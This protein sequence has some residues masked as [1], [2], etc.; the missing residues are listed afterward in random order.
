MAVFRSS[1]QGVRPRVGQPW[2]PALALLLICCATASRGAGV[3]ALP[4]S[5]DESFHPEFLR[6]GTVTR[7]AVVEGGG[8]YVAGSFTQLQ[9]TPATNFA[10]LDAQGKVDRSFAPTVDWATTR[11][12]ALGAPGASIMV[13][14]LVVP[15][16]DGGVLVSG[17]QLESSG[18]GP[19]GLMR[20][21]GQGKRDPHF[22]AR[23]EALVGLLDVAL[24]GAVV[25]PDGRIVVMGK[26]TLVNGVPRQNIARLMPDGSV[27]PSF[28]LP[29][30][31]FPA[32]DLWLTCLALQADGRILVGGTTFPSTSQRGVAVLFRLNP[33]GSMDP[34]FDRS[35]LTKITSSMPA[36]VSAVR[37]QRD[38]KIVLG[39][40]FGQYGS[41]VR[42]NPDGTRDPSFG[43]QDS[44]VT[45]LD[46]L[47]PSGDPKGRW[48]GVGNW[49]GGGWGVLRYNADGTVD[50]TFGLRTLDGAVLDAAVLPG[51]RLV[52]AGSFG[53]GQARRDVDLVDTTGAEQP[54]I[55]SVLPGSVWSALPDPAGRTYV[56]G[57]FEWVNGTP[58]TAIARLNPDG[59]LDE[60]FTD[61]FP[62]AYRTPYSTPY[63]V[64]IA[65][66]S[67]QR[68]LLYAA[69]GY[70]NVLARLSSDGSID[71]TW[72]VQ[73]ASAVGPRFG[74][75]LPDGG[76]ML[77]G[78]TF[79]TLGVWDAFLV[80]LTP[81]G[82]LD[83]SFP[84]VSN[85]PTP[86]LAGFG[87]DSAGRVVIGS[88]TTGVRRIKADGSWDD[89]FTA[90]FDS[91]DNIL[92][93]QVEPDGVVF[94]AH[95]GGYPGMPRPQ[96]A[97][98]FPDGAIDGT[99]SADL[100]HRG[101]YAY[102]TD[103]TRLPDGRFLV[104]L[105]EVVEG[106]YLSA[107]IRLEADGTWDPGFQET[108]ANSGIEQVIALPDGRALV[109]GGFTTLGGNPRPFLAV[110][111]GGDLPGVPPAIETEPE[112][113]TVFE[114][115][116]LA[117]TVLVTG[118]GPLRYEW[119]RD[120]IPVPDAVRR[121]LELP[122]T[123]SW[124][125]G[126]YAVIVSNP[127]GSVTSVM[128]HVQ[129]I[130]TEPL[131]PALNNTSL[132]W[133]CRSP[134][135]DR[136][137]WVG[138]FDITHDGGA[139]A[140]SVPIGDNASAIL[141]APVSTS[142]WIQFWWRVSSETNFDYLQFWIDDR[143]YAA[144]SGESGWQHFVAEVHAGQRVMWMYVKDGS[145]SEGAD[146]GW[147]DE[148]SLQPVVPGTQY[149]IQSGGL[150]PAGAFRL[151]WN[152][153]PQ[154]PFQVE[155]SL[156]LI[157]WTPRSIGICDLFLMEFTDLEP[158]SKPAYFYRVVSP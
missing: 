61:A 150:T 122:E 23:F 19:L 90:P 128:A 55:R 44:T 148:V 74:T 11:Q 153:T 46:Y 141:S 3:D 25:Q 112:D 10:R 65:T 67:Q 73:L 114:G 66:D 92:T 53:A 157:H 33:D 56:S 86:W 119:L 1:T 49:G 132:A 93:L 17:W 149:S 41:L 6:A 29:T 89:T 123:H 100:R 82:D 38:Q 143:P 152:C 40:L 96:L 43:G 58:R 64:P 8:V 76:V 75:F 60:T 136:R 117:L 103:F 99:F 79:P 78:F 142:G 113:T 116:P 110:L 146:C 69:S 126:A 154:A 137:G 26:F 35:M 37:L 47:L 62:I 111:H 48:Y 57:E 32:S 83:P 107:V 84:P 147:V 30:G 72:T 77:G 135:G 87:V 133:E 18:P 145:G 45:R 16:A 24:T 28:D 22:V 138:L 158:A 31:F 121:N 102:A 52:L 2:V 42:L 144:L 109:R 9:G 155:G 108:P 81:T 50:R 71:P 115:S 127:Q 5:V 85:F 139:A 125:A 118:T 97:K 120:G 104:A 4:G 129:V 106:Q 131:G 156:D 13:S 94:V 68:L 95:I 151:Q 39:G 59:S 80:R 140:Q 34:G 54:W 63:L 15:L 105:E 20:L 70:S 7:V 14:S 36:V 130:Q 21:D 88:Y 12:V 98:L 91:N 101:S 134:D 27:D 51:D 124:E